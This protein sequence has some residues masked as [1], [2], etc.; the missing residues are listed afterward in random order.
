[1]KPKNACLGRGVY[2]AAMVAVLVLPGYVRAALYETSWIFRSPVV[3]GQSM[4][5]PGTTQNYNFSGQYFLTTWPLNGTGFS[6]AVQAEQGVASGNV[7]GLLKAKYD[8]YV[9]GSDKTTIHLSYGALGEESNIGTSLAVSLTATP[10]FRVE[11]LPWPFPAFDVSIP[12]SAMNM[13]VGAKKDYAGVLGQTVGASGSYKILPF[14][15]DLALI[16]AHL[17]FIVGQNITFTPKAISGSVNCT[18]MESGATRTVDALLT[19]DGND[20]AIE[21]PLD[22]KGHW[23]IDLDNFCVDDNLF[24]QDLTLGADLGIGI[25][26]LGAD[27]TF[28]ANFS[29]YRSDFSLAFDNHGS[30]GNPATDDNLGRFWIYAD[31]TIPEPATAALLAGGLGLLHRRRKARN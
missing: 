28:A 31:P 12:I 9:V 4:W 27:W 1:M 15:V 16:N 23:E 2:A 30:D 24:H 17:D 26:V 22:L 20:V 5:G 29:L 13:A 19:T 14:S 3:Q 21:L 7:E 8:S 11:L 18:H 25:P 6:W 10:R